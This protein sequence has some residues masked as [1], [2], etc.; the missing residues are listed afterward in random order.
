MWSSMA[1]DEKTIDVSSHT[2][3]LY[4]PMI[5]NLKDYLDIRLSGFFYAHELVNAEMTLMEERENRKD[6]ELNLL[7]TDN[8]PIC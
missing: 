5:T 1:E 4:R 8:L 6:S 3:I 2:S 7:N